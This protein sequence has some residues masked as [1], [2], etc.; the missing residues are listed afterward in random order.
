MKKIDNPFWKDVLTGLIKINKNTE[1]EE[2]ISHILK[3]PIFYNSDICI[4]KKYVFWKDWYMKG[5]RFINDIVKENG[6]FYNQDELVAKYNIRTNYLH[7]QGIIKS[8]KIYLNSHKITLA[9]N[10]ESPLIPKRLKSILQQKTGTQSIYNILNKNS[11]THL[12]ECCL[13]I[14][15]KIS[16][17][18]RTGRKYL[19]ILSQKN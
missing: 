15:K 13:G 2:G 8:I 5:I 3:T 11:E 12:L 14:K 4:D 1:L 7:Y 10:I 17:V 19:Y 18:M 16:L 9:T 6:E